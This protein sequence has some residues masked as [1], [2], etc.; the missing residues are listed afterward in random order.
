MQQEENAALRGKLEECSQQLQS[1]EQMI[2]WLN[3]QVRFYLDL[4][5]VRENELKT[6]IPAFCEAGHLIFHWMCTRKI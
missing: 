6:T 4:L 2:R 1:N 5:H 3:N